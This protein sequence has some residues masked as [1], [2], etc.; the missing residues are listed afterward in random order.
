MTRERPFSPVRT[1][2]PPRA[3]APQANQA[4][5]FTTVASRGTSLHGVPSRIALANVAN[6]LSALTP[7]QTVIPRK[8]RPNIRPKPS[9]VVSARK[10]NGAGPRQRTQHRMW[11]D[12]KEKEH[13]RLAHRA[14]SAPERRNLRK[15]NAVFEY[16][17]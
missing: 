1:R 11:S 12:T 5:I 7:W 4:D 10:A 14:R 6:R 17:R 13:K 8:T 16:A 9:A 3:A 15:R 2:P